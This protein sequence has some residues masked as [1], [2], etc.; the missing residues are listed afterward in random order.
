MF[1]AVASAS[2]ITGILQLDCQECIDSLERELNALQNA[3]KTSEV[4]IHHSARQAAKTGNA[5][6]PVPAIADASATL[7]P[8]V[9]PK[10]HTVPSQP[11]G[12]VH[13]YA[14][15]CDVICPRPDVAHIPR[16]DPIPEPTSKGRDS[17]YKTYVLAYNP[18]VADD[19]FTRS[20]AT[21]S[22]T[23]TPRELLAL[24]PEV[25]SKY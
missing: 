20:L 23:L 9:P 25:C 24:A 11:T 15:A 2:P 12:P 18:K 8:R 21:P 5:T 3:A 13:P 4:P 7:P 1:E 16:A 10:T 19:I 6:K 14:S 22:I 17:G